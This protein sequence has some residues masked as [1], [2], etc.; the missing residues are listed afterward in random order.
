MSDTIGPVW[1]GQGEEHMFLGREMTQVKEFSEFAAR[2]IDEEILNIIKKAEQKARDLLTKNRSKL[3]KL[4]AALLEHETLESDEIA[5]LI[6]Q[7][8]PE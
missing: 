5:R 3:D 8:G 4:A 2:E 7:K 1:F 6:D